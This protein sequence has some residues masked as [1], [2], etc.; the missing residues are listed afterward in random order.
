MEKLDVYIK[1][2]FILFIIGF[3]SLVVYVSLLGDNHKIEFAVEQYFEALKNRDYKTPCPRVNSDALQPLEDCRDYNFLLETAFLM[4]YGLME[5]NDYSL[6]IKTSHFWIPWISNDTVSISV[7]MIPKRENFIKSFFGNSKVY[8]V[9]DFM[10]VKKEDKIWQVQ[11]ISVQG[12]SLSPL[13][14]KVRKDINIHRY[15]TKGENGFFLNKAEVDPEKF[16]SVERR[17]FKYSMS[18]LSGL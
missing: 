7:A 15:I 13:F 2:F 12:S 4:H 17:L 11:S 6:V 1:S 18:R 5:E 10:T 8:Y 14:T 3:L 16:T 9:S